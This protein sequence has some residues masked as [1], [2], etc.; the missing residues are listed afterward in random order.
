MDFLTTARFKDRHQEELESDRDTC[1]EG[2]VR[3]YTASL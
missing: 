3:E 2:L 1:S